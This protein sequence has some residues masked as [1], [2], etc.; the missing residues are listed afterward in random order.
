MPIYIHH[1][2]TIVA[3][4]YYF[5]MVTQTLPLLVQKLQEKQGNLSDANFAKILGVSRSMW[6]HARQGTKGVG[7][8]ILSGAYKAF[9]D[10][11]P[12]IYEFVEAYNNHDTSGGGP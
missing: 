3:T 4:Y 6:G 9:P 10:L 11:R 12:D 1:I 5:S 2:D 7:L 8:A